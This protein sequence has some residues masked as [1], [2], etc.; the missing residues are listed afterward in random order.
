MRNYILENG[1]IEKPEVP[2]GPLNYKWTDS[3]TLDNTLY[4][5]GD[6]VSLC[7]F[8]TADIYSTAGTFIITYGLSKKNITVTLLPVANDGD[9]TAQF[10]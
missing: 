9:V 1:L 3:V 7:Y 4:R 8:T 10:N 2:N 6:M 5:V